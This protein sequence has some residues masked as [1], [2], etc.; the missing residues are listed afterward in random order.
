MVRK[1]TLE[2]KEVYYC[3]ECGFGYLDEETAQKCEGW[4]ST[5]NSC[6][7]DITRNSITRG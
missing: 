5:H 4:C 7:M 1:G 2:E 6:S 3:G